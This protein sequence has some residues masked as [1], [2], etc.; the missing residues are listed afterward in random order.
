MQRRRQISISLDDM[1]VPEKKEEI[2]ATAEQEV[3]NIQNQFSSGL[4]TQGERYNK[5]V[6][7][8]SRTNDLIANAMMEKLG[9][10]EVEDQAGNKK[11]QPSFN[12]IFMMA[13]SG[14]RGSARS[15]QAA[16]R[17]ERVDG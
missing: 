10:E 1:E 13:D 7:I 14:A 6:D 12:S 3:K 8:W 2:L 16:R 4:L 9:Q 17:H 15:D 11:I 5:V